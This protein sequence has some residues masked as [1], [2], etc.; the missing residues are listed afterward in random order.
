M[1]VAMSDDDGLIIAGMWLIAMLFGAACFIAA[2]WRHDWI[3]FGVGCA[4][5]WYSREL[6]K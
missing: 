4:C 2:I 6:L 1:E 5:W 3:A